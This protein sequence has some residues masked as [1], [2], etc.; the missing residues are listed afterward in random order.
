[1]TVGSAV[2]QVFTRTVARG[3]GGAAPGATIETIEAEA[4][5]KIRK[6]A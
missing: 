5:V 4:G 6:G 3:L 2:S 1:M